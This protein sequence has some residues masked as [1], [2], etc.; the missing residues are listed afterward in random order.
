MF[1]S[2][3]EFFEGLLYCNIFLPDDIKL[4]VDES[5][6]NIFSEKIYLN[7]DIILD[8]TDKHSWQ[9]INTTSNKYL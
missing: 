5:F 8:M 2:K 6:K 1:L 3:Y 7:Q 9:I 4:E